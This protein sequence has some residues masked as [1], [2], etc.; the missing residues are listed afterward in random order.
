MY[1]KAVLHDAVL[2]CLAFCQANE[3]N[4]PEEDIM[5]YLRKG[6]VSSALITWVMTVRGLF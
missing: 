5:H 6:Y 4:Y 2:D 3:L 1:D